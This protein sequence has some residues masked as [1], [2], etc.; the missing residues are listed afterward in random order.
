MFDS[1]LMFAT[2]GFAGLAAAVPRAMSANA[3]DSLQ[4][5]WTAVGAERDGREAADVIGHV[6]VFNGTTFSIQE[7]GA[8]I[9]EG[10]FT[11]D[12]STEPWTI[13][14]KH[15][16]RS[17]AGKTWLG[18]YRLDGEMLTICDNAGDVQNSRPAGFRTKPGSGLVMVTFERAQP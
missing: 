9:Y 17:L 5:T 4:G 3:T 10:T 15:T 12:A 1:C 8:T 7:K 11:A 14:F 18:V 2:L 13:D 6:V 16:G